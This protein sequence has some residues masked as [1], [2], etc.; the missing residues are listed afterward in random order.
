HN[1][2][3]RPR[4][5]DLLRPPD[6]EAARAALWARREQRARPG[7]DDKVLT[8][9]NAMAVAALAEAGGLLSRA[10]WIA[11]A[12]HLAAFLLDRLR[13]DGRWRR[14]WQ[15]GTARHLAYASDHAWLVE[16]YTR[17][18]EATG[19][20]RWV[21][22]ARACADALLG[23]FWDEAEGGLFTSGAD[24]EAL[25]ARSKDTY[26][27]AL[28]SANSVAAS[29]LLRLGTLTGEERYTGA[30]DALVDAMAPA[31]ARAPLAFSGLVAAADLRRGGL[32]EVVVSGERLD[33]VATV[34][35]RYRPDVVLAWGE[36]YP[37]P[38]WQ[39]R[40]GGVGA[41]Y[42]CRDYACR[43]PATSPGE[44]EAALAG[45]PSGA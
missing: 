13:V 18:S 28:P 21:T 14:S 37:S 25:I 41:G 9:W 2:L 33:L 27:G 1:I 30:A 6:V 17:L 45:A 12:E 35:A 7:L 15:G 32:V 34:R 44:L 36:P 42:V 38:L 11:E 5:G 3:W 40:E 8:E 23:L 4:R 29:A 31:L 22:E 43:A 20:A 26:D 39:G 19:R 24:A 16:A 10:D